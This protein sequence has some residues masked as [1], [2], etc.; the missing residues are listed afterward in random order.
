MKALGA[1]LLTGLLVLTAC[2]TPDPDEG[3]TPPAVGAAEIAQRLD[4]Y[5]TGMA[6]QT[7]E[8]DAQAGPITRGQTTGCT[9]NDVAWGVVPHAERT[10]TA[11]A[12]ARKYSEDLASWVSGAGVSGY[13]SRRI[14]GDQVTTGV[15]AD[16]VRLTV[17]WTWDTPRL[18]ISATGPCSWP[19]D[20]AGGPAPVPL[21]PPAGPEWPVSAG[22]PD[23]RT[24]CTS[25]KRMVFN[26]GAPPF[27][28]PGPHPVVRARSWWCA[29]GWNPPRTPAAT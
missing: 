19:A 25:P 17:R 11:D 1:V 21:P 12:G 5:L 2:S 14:D 18:T 3:K 27:A 29:C 13:E 7:L 20:R 4:E 15:A 16:G 28:G 10:V 8:S 9:E 22:Y 26:A 6:E 23:D 24:V